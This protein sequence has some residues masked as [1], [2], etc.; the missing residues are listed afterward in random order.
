M[1]II[2]EWW[3]ASDLDDA[4]LSQPRKK[5]LL[6]E[7]LPLWT[8]FWPLYVR[9]SKSW[10]ELIWN[11]RIPTEPFCAMEKVRGNVKSGWEACHDL[12]SAGL[13]E[14]RTIS[15][16]SINHLPFL[17]AKTRE[18]SF[19]EIV[20]IKFR[21][22][23]GWARFWTSFGP[24]SSLETAQ[25]WPNSLVIDEFGFWRSCAH[26]SE[27]ARLKSG[28]DRCACSMISHQ[29]VSRE[30]KNEYLVAWGWWWGSKCGRR[31]LI[32]SAGKWNPNKPNNLR[33][34]G[35]TSQLTARP[36]VV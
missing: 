13:P 24:F 5:K 15:T 3:G 1:Q 16:L 8:E 20:R 27:Y 32:S 17:S 11:P 21:L 31:T 6:H 4:W 9:P 35:S 18:I 28:R 33:A 29:P 10:I 7:P 22:V 26:L 2:T 30:E 23:D 14:N 36:T 25:F 12:L 19:S 34:T